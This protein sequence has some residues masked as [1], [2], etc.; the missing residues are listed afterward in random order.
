MR[1]LSA[2][3]HILSR[4]VSLVRVSHTLLCIT[5]ILIA[6]YSLHVEAMLVDIP[7][8]TPACDIT[9]WTMSC[10]KV[11]NSKYARPLSNWGLVK[12]RSDLDFSLPQMA[13]VY[14]GLM[15]VF[16]IISDRRPSSKTWFKLMSYAALAFN[17]YLAYV[18]KF[19]L[20]EFCIVCVSNYIVNLALGLTV[21]RISKQ[22]PPVV[23][24]TRRAKKE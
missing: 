15:L 7:G 17:V 4:M 8:Y 1:F 11:F 6:L 9:A 16:P 3:T 18:L 10:S 14:F 2:F 5:G 12:G 22:Q 23:T 21:N 24:H 19:K 20:G 13:I